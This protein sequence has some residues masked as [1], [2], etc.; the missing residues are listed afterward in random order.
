MKILQK[1]RKGFFDVYLVCLPLPTVCLGSLDNRKEL[2]KFVQSLSSL[3]SDPSTYST[4]QL[5]DFVQKRLDKLLDTFKV[6]PRPIYFKLF[7][8]ELLYLWSL[9]A[10]APPITLIVQGKISRSSG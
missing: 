2:D 3:Q 5:D 4:N 7:I 10:S 1:I 9:L 6:A 8:Y